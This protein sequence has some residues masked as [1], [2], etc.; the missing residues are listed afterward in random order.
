M[1]FL[2]QIKMTAS[3]PETGLSV[4]VSDLYMTFEVTKDIG[5]ASNTCRAKIYNAS[6]ETMRQIQN[7][8]NKAPT[9]KQGQFVVEAGYQDEQV[10]GLFF[11]NFIRATPIRDGTERYLDIEAS[12]GQESAQNQTFA[13]SYSA[14]TPLAAVFN[15]LTQAIGLPVIGASLLPAGVTYNIG[16]GSAAAGGLAKDF[17][18][19]VLARVGL[20]WTIQNKQLYILSQSNNGQPPIVTLSMTTGLLRSPEPIVDK[21]DM[22][23]GGLPPRNRWRL[24]ALL[25]PQLTA[26]SKVTV[27][28]KACSG[29]FVVEKAVFTGDNRDGDFHVVAEVIDPSSA[30]QGLNYSASAPELSE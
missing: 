24:T 2:R 11:G 7:M 14:G 27:S 22:V 5:Q 26:G 13:K 18:T 1:A 17:L 28:S 15:D 16:Y 23:G 6:T 25:I 4:S 20:S 30:A 29:D 12:D 9:E 8:A 19:E 21:S 10:A 3:D